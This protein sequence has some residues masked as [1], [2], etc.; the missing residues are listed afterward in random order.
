M[1][2]P[3]QQFLLAK[4]VF[5]FEPVVR[6]PRLVEFLA[7]DFKHNHIVTT[8]ICIVFLPKTNRRRSNKGSYAAKPVGQLPP[9]VIKRLPWKK[10]L[11]II[12]GR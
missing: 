2:S 4:Y 11:L 3:Y 12:V 10:S 8:Y 5:Q 1:E 7:H 9:N 6:P